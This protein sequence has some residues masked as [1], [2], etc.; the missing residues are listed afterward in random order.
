MLQYSFLHS[1]YQISHRKCCEAL[2]WLKVDTNDKSEKKF[3]F[4][5]KIG[6][7]ISRFYGNT[8][9]VYSFFVGFLVYFDLFFVFFPM[10]L[11]FNK[12]FCQIW[13]ND[14]VFKRIPHLLSLFFL[15]M[16]IFFEFFR[17]LNFHQFGLQN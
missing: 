12:F 3:H 4:C 9:K 11:L 5:A 8:K 16:L 6:Q 15:E 13:S 10:C 17:Y 1:T 7:K 14:H 2:F